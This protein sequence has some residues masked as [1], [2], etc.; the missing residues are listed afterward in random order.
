MYQIVNTLSNGHPP[1]ILPTIYRSVDLPSLFITHITNKVEKHRANIAR[2]NAASTR[3]TGTTT[4]T[5]SSFV[6]VSQSTVNECF[7]F[8]L[9]SLETLIPSRPNT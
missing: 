1:K 4:T 7:L 8:L 5:Y 9:Q 6:K 2:E 3:A